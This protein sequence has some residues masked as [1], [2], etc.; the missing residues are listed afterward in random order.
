MLARVEGRLAD[1]E[2][3]TWERLQQEI[4]DAVE[5][6]QDVAE[7]TNEEIHLLRAPETGS[8]ASAGF[9][10]EYGRGRP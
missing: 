9:H 1:A 7:L 4:D 2:H 6:E 8:V 3:R 10:L 5:F